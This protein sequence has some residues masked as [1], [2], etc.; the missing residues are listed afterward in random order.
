[1][2][3]VMNFAFF[4]DSGLFI[5]SFMVMMRSVISVHSSPLYGSKFPPNVNLVLFGSDFVG[6][7]STTNFSYVPLLLFGAYESAMY[8]AQFVLGITLM[9]PGSLS[10]SFSYDVS[11]IIL[12]SGLLLIRYLWSKFKFNNTAKVRKDYC[13]EKHSAPKYENDIER[14]WRLCDNLSIP[15]IYTAHNSVF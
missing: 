12:D 8:F 11:H 15:Y 3:I 2:L 6:L 14:F 7:K 1:M 10:N 4:V 5:N 9:P 13:T